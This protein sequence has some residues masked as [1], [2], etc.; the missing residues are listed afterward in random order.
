M[1]PAPTPRPGCREWAITAYSYKDRSNAQE[2]A[3]PA[4]VLAAPICPTFSSSSRG[5][6]PR[7][8]TPGGER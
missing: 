2:A 3:L 5:A 6:F 4:G 1:A 7:E 8:S